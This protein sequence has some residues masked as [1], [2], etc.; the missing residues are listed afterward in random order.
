MKNCVL[1]F[2]F[3]ICDFIIFILTLFF[4]FFNERKDELFEKELLINIIFVLFLFF[5]YFLFF[6][7]SIDL[8]YILSCF[9]AFIIIFSK[10]VIQKEF[11][12]MCGRHQDKFG[13]TSVFS[14]KL[15]YTN[16]SPQIK[17]PLISV[18]STYSLFIMLVLVWK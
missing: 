18:H 14:F 3:I 6:Q 16:T 2:Q 5:I 10:W 4:I 9:S 17:K 7:K 12:K 8:F 15:N 1:L 13:L 11:L